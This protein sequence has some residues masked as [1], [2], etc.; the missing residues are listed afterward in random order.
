MVGIVAA[1][2][3][4]VEGDRQPLLP[5]GQRLAIEGVGILGGREAGIL[6]DGPGT[7]GIHRRA[8]AAGEGREAGQRI[9]MRQAFQ[10][11]GGIERLDGDALGRLP[12]QLVQRAALDLIG[13]KRAPVLQG[14]L[15]KTG[16]R[17]K[18]L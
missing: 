4:Q 14:L 12:V 16:H 8:R 10:V 5:A 7:L 17:S 15:V 6:A 2:G 18:L 3:R 1:V 13:R 9:D 11:F